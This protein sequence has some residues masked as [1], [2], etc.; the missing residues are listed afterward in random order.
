M[1]P[2]STQPESLPDPAERQTSAPLP[3]GRPP[4]RWLECHAG[5]CSGQCDSAFRAPV[6]RLGGNRGRV[7]QCVHAQTH[8]DPFHGIDGRPDCPRL[9][10][11]PEGG[12]RTQ[13]S[14]RQRVVPT[15]HVVAGVERNEAQTL[16]V[17]FRPSA[18]P[19][20]RTANRLFP[21]RHSRRFAVTRPATDDELFSER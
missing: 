2:A 3:A 1:R 7:G 14:V 9:S 17:N 6:G 15:S 20:Y 16:A 8:V 11:T 4:Q 13:L 5:A 18:Q 19:L 21:L 12:K 10:G